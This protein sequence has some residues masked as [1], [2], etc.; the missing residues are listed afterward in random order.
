MLSTLGSVGVTFV[1]G[2]FA[3]WGPKYIDMGQRTQGDDTITLDELV[4]YNFIVFYLNL[5]RLPELVKVPHGRQ[6]FV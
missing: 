4:T 3:A 5:L 6:L 2:A 1:A